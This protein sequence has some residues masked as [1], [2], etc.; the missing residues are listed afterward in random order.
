MW[1]ALT[2]RTANCPSR[3][4][5]IGRQYT[6]VDSMATCVQPAA[7]NHSPRAR[8]SRV[9]VVNRRVSFRRSPAVSTVVRHATSSCLCTSRPQQ[10]GESTCLLALLLH[11]RVALQ[12][13]TGSEADVFSVEIFL[14]VLLRR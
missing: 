11:A 13:T 8:M 14:Y 10:H 5:Q 3:R 4:F 7:A 2:S 9:M 1:W 12:R 6:P